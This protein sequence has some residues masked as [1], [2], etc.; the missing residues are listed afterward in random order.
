MKKFFKNLINDSLNSLKTSP[1]G[2][3]L[4]KITALIMLGC[5]VYIHYD[6]VDLDNSVDVVMYDMLFILL[7]FGIVTFDQL[8]KFKGNGKQEKPTEETKPIEPENN[9]NSNSVQ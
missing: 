3:S 8:Y 9:T 6:Y 2:F 7:L 1:G 4:R 5:I